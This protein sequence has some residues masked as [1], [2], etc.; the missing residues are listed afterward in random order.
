[1]PIVIKNAVPSLLTFAI[2]TDA[3]AFRTIRLAQGQEAPN[4]AHPDTIEDSNLTEYVRD[5]ARRGF[6]EL[7]VGEVQSASLAFALAASSFAQSS[8]SQDI[9]LRVTTSDSQVTE[10][11][12]TV[13]VHDLLT[14]TAN[15]G[16]VHYTYTPNPKIITI[17]AG[18]AHNALIP[19]AILIDGGTDPSSLTVD[20]GLQNVSGGLLQ[21]PTAH[22]VTL[23]APVTG[24]LEVTLNNSGAGPQGVQANG[25][26]YFFI[27][28]GETI[29]LIFTNTHPTNP[30]TVTGW[31]VSGDVDFS[32][33]FTQG[34]RLEGG[35]PATPT[36]IAPLSSITL[37]FQAKG[38]IAVPPAIH[39]VDVAVV[40]DATNEVSPFISSIVGDSGGVP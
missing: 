38:G 4:A 18:T 16:G 14:G 39:Q 37:S 21:T 5:L 24:S 23:A 11:E 35:A 25:G 10:N 30:L 7:V 17:P 12:I 8:G 22:E 13:E 3:G 15:G 1:M 31:G 32:G 19:V 6:I 20:L 26:N 33:G 40:H 34:F 2:R 29:D 27:A 9:N 36:V 28:A